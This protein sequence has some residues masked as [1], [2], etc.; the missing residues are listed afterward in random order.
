MR[1]MLARNKFNCDSGIEKLNQ[2][3]VRQVLLQKRSALCERYRVRVYL[4]NIGKLRAWAY[5]QHLVDRQFHFA[6]NWRAA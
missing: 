4:G 6:D 2:G 3:C 5:Y 1:R